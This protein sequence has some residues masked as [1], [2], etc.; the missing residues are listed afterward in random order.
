MYIIDVV[1]SYIIVTKYSNSG[2]CALKFCSLVFTN[3]N[4]NY[5][6]KYKIKLNKHTHLKLWSI[7]VFANFF[8]AL[9]S[10]LNIIAYLEKMHK[11][12]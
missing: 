9:N 1:N 8:R 10:S 7:Y 11:T 3:F 2:H 12:I 6:D 5:C 4:C